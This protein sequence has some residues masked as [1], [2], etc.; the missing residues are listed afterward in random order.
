MRLCF[1]EICR[2]VGFKVHYVDDRRRALG[3]PHKEAF[4]QCLFNRGKR[5]AA[6]LSAGHYF[7][8]ARQRIVVWA[9]K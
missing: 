4:E 5:L 2:L 8:R 9:V 6:A 1:S 3:I 7:D